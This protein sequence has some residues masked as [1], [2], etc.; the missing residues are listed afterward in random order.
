MDKKILGELKEKLEAE[1][2]RLEDELKTFA[3]KDPKVKNNWDTKFPRFGEEIHIDE[4][5]NQEE[6]EEYLNLLPVEHRLELRLRDINNALERIE[7][8]TY[9]FCQSGG[10][11]H[12]IELERLKVNPEAKFC[13]KHLKNK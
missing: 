11:K 2:N 7:N 10:E 5:E 4:T 6:V 9:G 12:V 1:K 3:K 8:N 13:L